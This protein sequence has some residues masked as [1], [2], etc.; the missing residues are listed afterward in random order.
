MDL[1]LA[2][3]MGKPALAARETDSRD[4]PFWRVFRFSA[5]YILMA[6]GHNMVRE[7]DEETWREEALENPAL[8]RL[9][10]IANAPVG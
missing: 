2:L 4:Q 9:M 10:E 8:A 6:E 7:V 3:Y 1:K 5:Q